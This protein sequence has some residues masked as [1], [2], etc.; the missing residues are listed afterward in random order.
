[1]DLQCVVTVLIY[2]DDAAADDDDNG[3]INNSEFKPKERRAITQST[4]EVLREKFSKW[5]KKYPDLARERLTQ[6]TSLSQFHETINRKFMKM[7]EPEVRELFKVLD[8]DKCGFVDGEVAQVIQSSLVD[9][10]Y[11]YT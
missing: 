10:L 6:R 5:M 8:I 3:G 1:M 9:T 4:V 11:T 2:D 7:T